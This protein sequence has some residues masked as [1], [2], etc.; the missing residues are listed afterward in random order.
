[1]STKTNAPQ[2]FISYS[3]KP[4]LNREK[5]IQLAERLSSNF[6]HV[7]I[8]VWDL[9]E[10]QDKNQFMEQMVNSADV[11][12][13]LLIC[14]KDY[15]E[16]ANNRVGGVGIES[17][18][19]SNEIYSQAAQTKFIPVIFEYD[20]N[21]KPYVPTFVNSRIFVDLSNEEVF[22]E[23][24]EILMRNI[25]DKP[26]SKRPPLGTPPP[27]I[28]SDEP[29]F[30][31][32]AH[33]VT[34]IKKALIE[35]KKNAI[36][37]IQDYYDTFVRALNDFKIDENDL[38]SENYDDIVLKSIENLTVLRDDFINFL[39]TYLT[40]SI[41][42][43]NERLHSFFEKLLDFLLNL[44]GIEHQS[45]TFTSIKNDNYRFF[46]YEFFLYFTSVMFEKERFKELA[47]ILHNPFILNIQ[48]YNKTK[49][50]NFIFFRN[51][52]L[53]LN[54]LR[55]KKLQMNRIS[56]TADVIK[57]RATGKIKF[58][59]LQQAD[60]LLYYISLFLPD[61][62][63][64]Y[65]RSWFPETTCYYIYS[66]PIMSKAIS[67]K[68]FEK[69]KVIFDVNSKDELMQKIK[70]ANEKNRDNLQ[71]FHYEIPHLNKGLNIDEICTIR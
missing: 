14:N 66:F 23:N 1:M 71:R 22:E 48:K 26:L 30:L 68:F 28:E 32:T 4:V 52:V 61:I 11:K 8:D 36:I 33:K 9:K 70:Y 49:E 3:W 65:Q 56:L 12:R 29:I 15:A 55:N 20:E 53:T 60:A 13:V 16:K 47:Y 37:F 57:A 58:T 40:Y 25:F 69:L 59:Q 24:Y 6:V 43:D 67:Q 54:D 38:T 10:G 2:I 45:N 5:V 17:L 64:N 41:E 19:I 51:Y 34:T 44:D 18:I 62:N 27:Y 31:A 35:E 42:I 39:E 7:I 50:Y 46:F 21:S 63:S